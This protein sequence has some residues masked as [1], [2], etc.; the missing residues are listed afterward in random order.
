[1]K[2]WKHIK[3]VLIHRYA[4][5]YT[6]DKVVVEGTIK[7]LL[8]KRAKYHDLDRVLLYSLLPR[9][10]ADTYHLAYSNHHLEECNLCDKSALDIYESVLNYESKGYTEP[11]KSD[12]AWSVI[13]NLES[14]YK[15]KAETVCESL[16]IDRYY[17]NSP[18]D[19]VWCE[20]SK[21]IPKMTETL[22]LKELYNW[23]L[24]NRESAYEL[25]EF[26]D[27]VS[28]NTGE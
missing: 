9:D 21:S 8:L 19:P 15:S 4:L 14:P 25:L 13:K 26:V 20:Y 17:Q 28:K 12:S 5:V 3:R 11:G 27:R 7:D 18:S 22:V 6:I 1:M 10:I 24:N 23:V 16:G 2:N